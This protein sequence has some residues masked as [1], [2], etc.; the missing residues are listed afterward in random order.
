MQG[1]IVMEKIIIEVDNLKCGGCANT[2]SKGIL[3]IEG[4]TNVSVDNE[5][6]SVTYEGSLSTKDLVLTKLSSMG[7]PQKG[8]LS[9][10]NAGLASAKSYV[11]CAIGKFS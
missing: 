9:G 2:I 7:Y 6:E 10:L 11:S 1:V 5:N 4:V 3:S 8:S